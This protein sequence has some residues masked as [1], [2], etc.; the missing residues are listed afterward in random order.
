MQNSVTQC[1]ILTSGTTVHHPWKERELIANGWSAWSPRP[2]PRFSPLRFSIPSR[3]TGSAP[4]A[5]AL[6]ANEMWQQARRVYALGGRTSSRRNCYY[7]DEALCCKLISSPDRE[8]GCQPLFRLKWYG[9]P[10]AED[11]WELP[12]IAGYNSVVR[13]R[14]RKELLSLEG[15]LWSSSIGLDND[16]ACMLWIPL[17]IN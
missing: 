2:Y 1:V 17:R 8:N 4:C 5:F 9:F 15:N 16:R 3:R 6:I 14:R 10:S 13:C 7:T 11:T 12:E